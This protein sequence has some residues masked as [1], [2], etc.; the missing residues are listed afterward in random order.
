MQGNETENSNDQELKEM[1]ALRNLTFEEIFKLTYDDA[2]AIFK[3]QYAHLVGVQIGASSAANK[4]EVKR[5]TL[6][7]WVNNGWVKVYQ[8]ET[9]GGAGRQL[10]VDEG[11]VAALAAMRRFRKGKSGPIKGWKP[12]K[13]AS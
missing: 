8:A 9:K 5:S 11:Q 3:Q 1:L 10:M 2:F 7:D 13:I 12:E 6:T 4:Y